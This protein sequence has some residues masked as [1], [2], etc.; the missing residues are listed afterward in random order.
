[1]M[2]HPRQRLS[3]VNPRRI[4]NEKINDTYIFLGV[5]P[6]HSTPYTSQDF[7]DELVDGFGSRLNEEVEVSQSSK[8][9]L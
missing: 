7:K 4:S 3:K 5:A 9:G 1:M 2:I 6:A 8:T